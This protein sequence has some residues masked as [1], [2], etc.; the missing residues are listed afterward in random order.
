MKKLIPALALFALI[1][2]A[3]KKEVPETP[4]INNVSTERKSMVFDF[5]GLQCGICTGMLPR[6]DDMLNEHKYNTIGMSVHCGVQDSLDNNFTL[7]MSS[8]FNVQGT[9]SWAEGSSMAGVTS[10]DNMESAMKTTLT[11]K[12]DIGI[13]IKAVHSG[14]TITVTTKTVLFNDLSGEY[15][16]AIYVQEDGIHA[17]QTGTPKIHNHVLRGVAGNN[18]WGQLLIGGSASK[19]TQYDNTFSYNIGTQG[20]D[21]INAS[22]LHAVA[23]IYKMVNGAPVEVMNCNIE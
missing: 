4:E 6:W 12:A 23:V 1:A 16:I 20:T 14:N 19:G 5:T 15:N 13:G 21:Y 9:P 7:W 11:K 22:N 3:C 17:L 2:N 18:M 10:Y 8:F